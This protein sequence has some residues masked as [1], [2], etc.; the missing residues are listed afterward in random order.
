MTTA[1]ELKMPLNYV[2]MDAEEMEYLE[3]GG[4][5]TIKLSK[6]FVKKYMRIG[7]T[8]QSTRC[9]DSP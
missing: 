7:L 3:G 6:A 9:S 4:T 8:Q 2:E 5:V 1:V